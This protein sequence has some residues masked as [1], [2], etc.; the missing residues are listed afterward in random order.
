V[1]RWVEDVKQE[2]GNDVAIFIVGNK[3]DL[4]HKTI[5]TEEV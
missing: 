4:E 5:S 1:T 3:I 2:R